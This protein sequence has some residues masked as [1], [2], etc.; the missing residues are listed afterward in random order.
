MF[1][2]NCGTKVVRETPVAVE[3][4]PANDQRLCPTCGQPVVKDNLFCNNCG[5]KL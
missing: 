3:A 2:N 1:C 4:A 5:S